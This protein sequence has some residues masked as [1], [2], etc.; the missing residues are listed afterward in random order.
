MTWIQTYTGRKFYPLDPRA[1][2]VCIE[3][4]AHALSMKCR[5]SGHCLVFYS[6]A[7]HSLR[8]AHV[9][10]DLGGDALVQM[11]ALLHDAAEAYLPDVAS[12]IKGMF[13]GRRSTREP[14][15]SFEHFES[16]V[17]AAIYRGL[18]VEQPT[19]EQMRLVRQADLIMLATEKRD[20]MAPTEHAWQ[21]LPDPLEARIETHG[22]LSEER[23]PTFAFCRF[24]DEYRDLRR[25]LAS[26]RVPSCPSSLG[27]D[28]GSEALG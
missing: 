10:R 8:C 17:L 5:F 21:P 11:H 4:I 12:P 14:R 25:Q 9:V 6:V 7:E 22:E 16:C 18:G 15:Y 1:S 13:M 26:L 23:T 28:P 19:A 2:D 20:L 24:M 27:G 3:D